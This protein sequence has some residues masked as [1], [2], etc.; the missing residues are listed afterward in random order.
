LTHHVQVVAEKEA[1]G[2]YREECMQLGMLRVLGQEVLG[3]P[4]LDALDLLKRQADGRI[5][6]LELGDLDLAGPRLHLPAQRR[7]VHRHRAEARWELKV[8][9]FVVVNDLVDRTSGPTG[10]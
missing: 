2:A 5:G 8:L 9:L 3:V 1:V 6:M 4:E 7:L 10:C